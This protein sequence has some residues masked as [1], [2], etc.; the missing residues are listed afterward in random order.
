[1]TTPKSISSY[2][3]FEID[4]FKD[5]IGFPSTKQEKNNKTGT[6]YFYYGI[7]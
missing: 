3:K 5:I 6:L 7:Y 4:Y 2:L 1:M